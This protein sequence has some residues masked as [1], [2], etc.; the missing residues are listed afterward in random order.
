MPLQGDTL[1]LQTIFG[2]THYK[3]LLRGDTEQGYSGTSASKVEAIA[4]HLRGDLGHHG[5]G[6][7]GDLRGDGLN[8][9]SR[10]GLGD[11]CHDGSNRHR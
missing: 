2:A 7:G 1:W 6:G 3:K 10:C 5:R 11:R 9:L 4:A 8:N